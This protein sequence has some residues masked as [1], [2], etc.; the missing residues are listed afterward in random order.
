MSLCRNE[1]KEKVES[2]YDSHAGLTLDINNIK[3]PCKLTSKWKQR[4]ENHWATKIK[5]LKKYSD[6]ANIK[7]GDRVAV[8]SKC[9]E[10]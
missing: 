7:S 10:K 8:V 4:Y 9:F 5:V 6:C 3:S 1:L 2:G